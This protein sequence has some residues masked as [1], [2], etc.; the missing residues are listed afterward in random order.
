[1]SKL[2]RPTR[3]MSTLKGRITQVALPREGFTPSFTAEIFDA[4]TGEARTLPATGIPIAFTFDPQNKKKQGI[5][6]ALNSERSLSGGTYTFT[7]TLRGLSLDNFDDAG[8]YA[9]AKEWV[10]GTEFGI[11]TSP[12]NE[13]YLMGLID[14]TQRFRRTMEFEAAQNFLNTLNFVYTPA[15]LT[16]GNA[17]T[18]SATTWGN[19]DDGEFAITINGVARNVTGLDFS[20]AGNNDQVA[21]I[22]QAA[23]RALTSSTEEVEW[24]GTQFI[25]RSGSTTSSS[26][27]T[28]LSAVAAGTGTDI[29]GAGATA[30]LD[31]ETGRGT[32]SARQKG[33]LISGDVADDTERNALTNVANG[34][35]IYQTDTGTKWDYLAG[36]WIERASGGGFNNASET[37]SGGV[38]ILTSA[39]SLTA[40]DTPETGA[41]GMIRP[42]H[43]ARNIQNASYTHAIDTSVSDAYTSA[44]APASTGYVD[45][46]EWSFE[47]ITANTGPATMNKNS[48]L[49]AVHIIKGNYAALETGDFVLGG[50]YKLKEHVKT[51]TFTAAPTG[52]ETSRT[53]TANWAYTTG[54]YSVL[55]SNGDRRDVTLTN[56]ATTATW[57][58]ALSA[59]ATV[60][61]YAQWI[62]LLSP[63]SAAPLTT[64]GVTT[65][66][67][68]SN[69]AATTGASSFSP[70]ALN[71][72]STVAHG[73]GR[74]P[75]EVTV[76]W[77]NASNGGDNCV[78][79][80]IYW[81]GT[82][83]LSRSFS[84][85]A[86]PGQAHTVSTGA[87]GTVDAD[88]TGS[89]WSFTVSFD[90]TNIILTCS[91]FSSVMSSGGIA[92]GFI[93]K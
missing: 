83:G 22:I 56:G 63:V 44:P 2:T 29:S 39:Q 75:S 60:T 20:N 35:E 38:E 26:A 14:G 45:G 12:I 37:A 5:E 87:V 58:G 65:L 13:N 41:F 43:I 46:A 4:Y 86:N 82:S 32:V 61:A 3:K 1:M 21:S 11:T 48:S 49:G 34:A 52:G 73:L 42:S 90:A 15:Y 71:N 6:E 10:V 8:S 53:L 36:S 9:N 30:F 59:A 16:C 80:E 70:A 50:S 27:I 25:F 68:A 55:F 51:V 19:V 28:V 76:W 7:N 47:P 67:Q 84:T 85:I 79:G 77:G 64:S 92:W 62:Q 66:I 23:I 89:D 57:S 54:V 74:I 18:T 31:G 88:Q 72:T 17:P 81:N 33:F 24:D 93:A 91:S 69:A 40:T 78:R